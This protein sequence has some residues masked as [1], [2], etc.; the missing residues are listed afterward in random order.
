MV[1]TQR[2]LR[3]QRI[4]K[5]KQ[6]AQLP[7]QRLSSASTRPY[8]EKVQSF[9][10]FRGQICLVLGYGLV[11]RHKDC[12]FVGSTSP[13]RVEGTTDSA[14]ESTHL[15]VWIVVVVDGAHLGVHM[16]AVQIHFSA[17]VQRKHDAVEPGG[18]EVLE[19]AVHVP[20]PRGVHRVNLLQR[21]VLAAPHQHLQGRCERDAHTA[22]PQGGP[23]GGFTE[24]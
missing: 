13:S 20:V 10:F 9:N 22:T 4:H 11:V 16:E 19:R 17:A 18:G 2:S 24:L 12:G 14:V 7:H 5:R 23:G 8:P 1:L 15:V 6:R 21:V 3:T